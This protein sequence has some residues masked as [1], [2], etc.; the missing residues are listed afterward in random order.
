MQ[1]GRIDTR[2]PRRRFPRHD[3]SLAVLLSMGYI[4]Q[5]RYVRARFSLSIAH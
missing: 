1:G 5:A 3:T 4:A 2:F